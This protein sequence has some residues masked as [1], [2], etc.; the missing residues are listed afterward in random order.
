MSP[1]VKASRGMTWSAYDGTDVVTES[2][3]PP[4]MASPQSLLVWVQARHP[5]V[6]HRHR[7][8]HSTH[9]VA[10]GKEAWTEMGEPVSMVL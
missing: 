6:A 3:E 1:A 5:V 2:P 8:D 10:T 9:C 7:C 4:T